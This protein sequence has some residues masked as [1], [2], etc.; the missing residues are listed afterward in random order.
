MVLLINTAHDY[1]ITYKGQTL[2]DAETNETFVVVG[3]LI[4]TNSFVRIEST[5]HKR[6]KRGSVDIITTDPSK[7]YVR[8]IVWLL[9]TSGPHDDEL[10]NFLRTDL[11]ARRDA[12]TACEPADL[13]DFERVQGTS[14]YLFPTC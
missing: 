14:D 10:I 9:S 12:C 2:L 11:E 7:F 13:R 3:V 5:R 6:T 8:P 4:D 1:D